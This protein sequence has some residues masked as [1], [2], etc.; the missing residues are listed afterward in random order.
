MPLC[1]LPLAMPQVCVPLFSPATQLSIVSIA[2]A[3]GSSAGTVLTDIS[4]DGI[5]VSRSS[6][7]ITL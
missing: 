6:T 4:L 2:S 5:S 3:K 1:G 7:V